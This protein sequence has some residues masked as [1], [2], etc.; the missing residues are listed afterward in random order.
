MPFVD[1]L[2]HCLHSMNDNF[3]FQLQISQLVSE[4]QKLSD[5][6]RSSNELHQRA[7]RSLEHKIEGTTEELRLSQA[8][9]TTVQAEYDGYKVG[10]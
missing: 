3:C 2:L 5:K 1:T 7:V 9:L 10:E 6:L 8:A 4:N